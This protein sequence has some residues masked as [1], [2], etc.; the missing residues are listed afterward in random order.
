M[1]SRRV[2]IVL[3][4]IAVSVAILLVILRDVPLNEVLESLREADLG[5]VLVSLLM[6][7]LGLVVRGIRWSVLLGRRISY[8]ESTHMITVTFLG[9]QLPF[10][11]GEVARSVLATRNGVPLATSASSIVAERLI[12][13]L[14]VVLVI[15]VSVS[16][17]PGALP[18]VTERAL[19]FGLLALVGFIVL[20]GLA[21]FPEFAQRFLLDYAG[22]NSTIAQTA[23][24][25]DPGRLVEWLAATYASAR[26]DYH[27][28]LDSCR[29]GVFADYFLL[30]ALGTR[31]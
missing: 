13:T 14:V 4:S 8:V 27:W 25:V 2:F 15:A 10:R 9:N 1:N 29:L 21:R 19:L 30:P 5:Y 7:L 3:A 31:H 6:I 17:L 22:G 24:G 18:E 20:L 28:L 26:I 16:Q 12:D 23:A 11:L